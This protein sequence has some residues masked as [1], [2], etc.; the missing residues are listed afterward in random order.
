MLI[1][2][3]CYLLL[4]INF[5]IRNYGHRWYAFEKDFVNLNG[6]QIVGSNY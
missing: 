4:D 5:L 6:M 2:R 3:V 1:G